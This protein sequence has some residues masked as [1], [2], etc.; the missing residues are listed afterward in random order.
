MLIFDIRGPN[1]DK[2]KNG[3]SWKYFILPYIYIFNYISKFKTES[4][5]SNDSGTSSFGSEN[6]K[7]SKSHLSNIPFIETIKVKQFF[8]LL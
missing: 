1:D 7:N 4:D 8:F 5:G 6:K 2:S 3:M